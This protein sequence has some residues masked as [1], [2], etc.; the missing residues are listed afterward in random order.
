MGPHISW[1]QRTQRVVQRRCRVGHQHPPPT[2]CGSSERRKSFCLS[3]SRRPRS[4]RGRISPCPATHRCSRDEQHR[5]RPPDQR[6]GRVRRKEEALNDFAES[7][8]AR[9]ANYVILMYER[10]YRCVPPGLG[11]GSVGRLPTDESVGYCRSSSGTRTW[12]IGRLPTDESVGY[13]RSSRRDSDLVRSGDN[14]PMNRWAI[15][16]RPSGT[17]TWKPL[18]RS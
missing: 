6:L 13:C 1:S 5:T 18:N 12:L 17:R 11:P 10:H 7:D 9:A 8:L 2:R 4:V 16:G 14:P 15:V 3:P